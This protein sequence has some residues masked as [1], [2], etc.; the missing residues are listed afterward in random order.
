[1]TRAPQAREALHWEGIRSAVEVCLAEESESELLVIDDHRAIWDE[2][3]VAL[4]SAI[5]WLTASE[6]RCF[7]YSVAAR[8]TIPQYEH[9]VWPE[10]STR[11]HHAALQSLQ[12]LQ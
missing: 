11:R 9:C 5:I 6:Q 10:H 8:V 4:A 7:E 12:S 3:L 2:D 1:M